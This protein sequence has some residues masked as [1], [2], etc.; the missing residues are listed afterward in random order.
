[1]STL[2]PYISLV[3]AFAGLATTFYTVLR[4][5]SDRRRRQETI[6]E[7]QKEQEAQALASADL[8]ILGDY[9]YSNLGNVTVS[10]YAR[11]PEISAKVRRALDGVG[12]FLGPDSLRVPASQGT[13][14]GQ[15][16]DVMVSEVND[17]MSKARED[18]LYGEVWN[19]L[20]RMRRTI[21]N[22]LRELAPMEVGARRDRPAPVGAL[23]DRMRSRG[24][25]DDGVT[26]HFRYAVQ[27]ANAAVHGKDVSVG[28]ADEAWR[29]ALLGLVAVRQKTKQ[30]D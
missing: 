11:N 6:G 25:I 3:A 9:I 10:A 8:H 29:S 28:Q 12:N 1:M 7:L 15:V 24:L 17:E 23:I 30:S 20:A 2:A 13:P 21:E 4:T 22:E 5:V 26:N 27:V 16:D 14:A 19:G 18:I